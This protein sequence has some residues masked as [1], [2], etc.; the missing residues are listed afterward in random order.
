MLS[1]TVMLIIAVT[2]GYVFGNKKRE[3][4][5][6]PKGNFNGSSSKGETGAA[7]SGVEGVYTSVS[8]AVENHRL[9]KRRLLPL[10]QAG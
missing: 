7:V 5:P 4:L 3:R 8:P 1:L 10:P 9:W 2:V 6:V